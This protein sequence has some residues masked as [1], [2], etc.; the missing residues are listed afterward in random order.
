MHRVELEVMA[1]IE[2][3]TGTVEE[4][5]AATAGEGQASLVWDFSRTD[6]I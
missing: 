2:L 3:Y 5:R 4:A 1:L 6:W